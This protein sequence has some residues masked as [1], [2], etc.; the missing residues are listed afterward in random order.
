MKA[1]SFGKV[2]GRE[3]HASLG[4][5]WLFDRQADLHDTIKANSKIVKERIWINPV[6]SETTLQPLDPRGACDFSAKRS[7]I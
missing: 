1:R 4:L 5:G 3:R 2:H 6:T 7:R